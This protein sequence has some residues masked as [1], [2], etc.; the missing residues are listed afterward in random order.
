MSGDE[1]CWAVTDESVLVTCEDGKDLCGIEIYSDWAEIGEQYHEI[2]RGCM[3]SEDFIV[4][5]TTSCVTTDAGI[6][7]HT[8]DCIKTC[9]SDKCNTGTFQTHFKYPIGAARIPVLIPSTF[10]V[11]V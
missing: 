4:D 5:T 3:S 6:T 1:A 8:R 9:D 2:L 11:R 10:H 7:G